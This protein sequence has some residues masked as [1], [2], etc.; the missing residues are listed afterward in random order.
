MGYASSGQNG[1]CQLKVVNDEGVDGF[2]AFD[3]WSLSTILS[4]SSGAHDA[5]TRAQER[6]AKIHFQ[7]F[8]HQTP[9]IMCPSDP[10]GL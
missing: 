9:R 10:P 3:P 7:P 1:S 4:I 2:T 8:P 6:L 5:T